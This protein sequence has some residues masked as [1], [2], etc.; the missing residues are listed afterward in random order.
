MG[1]LAAF[2]PAFT[3]ASADASGLRVDALPVS[4]DRLL[5][6]LVARRRDE[7]VRRARTAARSVVSP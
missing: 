6:A 2:L 4:P 5:E 3:N 1:S 7:R